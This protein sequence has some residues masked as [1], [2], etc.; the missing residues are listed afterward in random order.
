M[1]AGRLRHKL[2]LERRSTTKST[3][4]NPVDTWTALG[5]R[6][7]SIEPLMGKEFYATSAEHSRL[8]TR[9]RLRHDRITAKLRPYDRMID[10]SSSPAVIYDI[11]SIQN[12]REKDRELVLMCV[13]DAARIR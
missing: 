6:R 5:E 10:I 2:T 8:T 9:I 13:N 11:E 4:G 1:R 3:T 12:P 7:A